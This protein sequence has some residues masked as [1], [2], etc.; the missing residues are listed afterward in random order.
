[1]KWWMKVMMKCFQATCCT[2]WTWVCQW[3]SAYIRSRQWQW[4]PAFSQSHTPSSEFASS[5]RQTSSGTTRYTF[6]MFLSVQSVYVRNKPTVVMCVFVAITEP[7]MVCYLSPQLTRHLTKPIRFSSRLSPG[8]ELWPQICTEQ[9][10]VCN[11][12]KCLCCISETC[13]EHGVGVMLY[14]RLSAD[15]T[16]Q[17]RD[18]CTD[19]EEELTAQDK[20][21]HSFK[22]Q[23]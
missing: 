20:R 12:T 5:S 6:L 22:T 1:M 8:P 7:S 4:R 18:I 2:M 13:C 21:L 23:L 19:T 10:S 14:L 16:E 9:D 11:R 15:P 3:S 17:D